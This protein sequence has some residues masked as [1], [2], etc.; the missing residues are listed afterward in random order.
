MDRFFCLFNKIDKHY[1][2]LII[3]GLQNKE[4]I[5]PLL[6]PF[7]LELKESYLYER[8]KVLS[9]RDGL[10]NLYKRQYFFLSLEEEIERAKTRKEKFSIL[11]A[12][13]D[14]FKSYNDRYGHLTGG[15]YTS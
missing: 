7:Y 1:P 15:L 14:K 6:S 12:D 8:V 13:I 5:K 10:T 4:K 2:L 9:I 3:D 11:L